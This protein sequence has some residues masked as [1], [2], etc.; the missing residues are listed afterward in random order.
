MLFKKEKIQIVSI[1]NL[2]IFSIYNFIQTC[3]SSAK[4]VNIVYKWTEP[5][6]SL[7]KSKNKTPPIHTIILT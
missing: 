4:E 3:S 5:P 7:N 2:K 6:N 1:Q